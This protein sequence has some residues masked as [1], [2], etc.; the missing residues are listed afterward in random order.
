MRI[1][2]ITHYERL[3]GANLSLLQL[4]INEKKL[5]GDELYV[6]VNKEGDFTDALKRENIKYI[7]ACYFTDTVNVKK[8]FVLLRIGIKRFIKPFTYLR[9]WIK[10][11]KYGFFDIIHTN[12]SVISIGCFL[13]KKMKTKHVWHVREFGYEDYN[14]KYILSKKKRE[15]RYENSDVMIAISKAIEDEIYKVAPN[16]KCEVIYNGVKQNDEAYEKKIDSNNLKFCIVGQI[17][18]KKNQFEAVKACKILKDRSVKNFK[19]YIWGDGDE[20]YIKEIMKYI[21]ENFLGENIKFMGYS[22]DIM[23]KLK[24]MNVGIVPSVKEAFG[25]VTIEYMSN[26][27]PVIGANTG[28]TIELIDNG[29]DG[30]IYTLNNIE[31]LAGAMEKMLV[32][33]EVVVKMG[34]EAKQ[35]S[36]KYTA[37]MNAKKIYELY[38]K[39]LYL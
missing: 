1:L 7:K 31:E 30:I 28:G 24:D 14:L 35:K 20:N 29:K 38:K 34:I 25:R 11:K 19:L 23:S 8:K 10:I 12:S 32:S 36:K 9:V 37:D 17:C 21:D 6:L 33:P 26:Y 22:A 18:E 3:Y 39:V 13:A 4:I 5:Y 2:Y 15:K 27:M 16:A